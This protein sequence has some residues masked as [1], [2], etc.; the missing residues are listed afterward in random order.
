M[1]EGTGDPI[2]PSYP[3]NVNSR[4]QTGETRDCLDP[5]F[6]PFI[7]TNGDVW[8]C[9][10]FYEAALGNV[11]HMPF[12]EIM[13]NEEFQSLRRE[14]LTGNLRKTCV[15]CPSRGITSPEALLARLRSKMA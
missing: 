1:K 10:W 8:P 14:L 6:Q 11:H 13:N 5:W 15:D 12:S 4:P 7:Q 2:G 9:C 3:A